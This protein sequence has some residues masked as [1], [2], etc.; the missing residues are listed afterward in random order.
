MYPMTWRDDR[1]YC[2][3]GGGPSIQGIDLASIPSAWTVVAINDAVKHV[4]AWA[5][6]TVDG[7]YFDRPNPLGN[8]RGHSFIAIPEGRFDALRLGERF[9]TLL[10]WDRVHAPGL[11]ERYGIIRCGDSG[12]GAL[13]FAVLLGARRVV[14]LGFDL[15]PSPK[16]SHAFRESNGRYTSKDC[17][18]RVAQFASAVPRLYD[19]RVEVM[20]VNPDSAIDCFPR[21]AP[22]EIGLQRIRVSP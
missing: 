16:N 9:P 4:R 7:T 17:E 12:Y 2:L 11:S 21:I 22:E 3:V 1:A 8:H 5:F 20:N 13:N 6:F 10:R 18:R 19:L 14:L 15:V